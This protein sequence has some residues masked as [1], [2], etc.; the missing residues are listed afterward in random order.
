MNWFVQFLRDS[1]EKKQMVDDFE[2]FACFVA[3]CVFF[4]WVLWS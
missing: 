1:E 2:A 4:G 3:I